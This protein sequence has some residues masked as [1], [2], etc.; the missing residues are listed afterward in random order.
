MRLLPK[1]CFAVRWDWEGLWEVTAWVWGPGWVWEVPGCVWGPALPAP[2]SSH[3]LLWGCLS[4]VL[5]TQWHHQSVHLK[6]PPSKLDR[7][8]FFQPLITSSCDSRWGTYSCRCEWENHLWEQVLW[9]QT[10]LCH[11]RLLW[12]VRGAGRLAFKSPPA[13][14]NCYITDRRDWRSTRALWPHFFI[15]NW[16]E[17]QMGW[18]I[19]AY[20]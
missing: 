18:F 15:D 9:V 5:H 10:R 6:N 14:L 11:T 7:N 4:S 20:K 12:A 8:A 1:S 13:S 17:N 3:T 19:P 16:S 2:S